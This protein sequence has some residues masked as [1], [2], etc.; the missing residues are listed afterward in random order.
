MQDNKDRQMFA[1]LAA[2]EAG[3]GPKR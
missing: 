3:N 1:R 2:R